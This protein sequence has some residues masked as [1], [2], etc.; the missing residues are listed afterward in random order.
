MFKPLYVVSVYCETVTQTNREVAPLT[1]CRGCHTWIHWCWK[2][3]VQSPSL[4]RIW[5]CLKI[6][7]IQIWSLVTHTASS[8]VKCVLS[9]TNVW[10]LLRPT[11]FCC[12][13]KCSHLNQ[14]D[15]IIDLSHSAHQILT[16]IMPKMVFGTS[17]PFTGCKPNHSSC[18]MVVARECLLGHLF[19]VLWVFWICLLIITFTS[20]FN[21][22]LIMKATYVVV[23]QSGNTGNYFDNI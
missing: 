1:E 5:L 22:V 15:Y 3:S 19:D 14:I 21:F 2:T 10:C 4:N 16:S 20:F 8:H 12:C 23:W 11:V 13:E 18:Y 9:K 6:C 17:E 7:K